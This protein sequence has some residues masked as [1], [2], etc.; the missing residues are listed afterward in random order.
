M[1]RGTIW[2]VRGKG[3]VVEGG[4]TE[5]ILGNVANGWGCEQPIYILEAGVPSSKD[6][7]I[8]FARMSQILKLLLTSRQESFQGT[9][10]R[11]NIAK[12]TMDPGV[13]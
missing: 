3:W 10:S 11:E 2:T 6:K 13:A 1:K 5:L 4:L 8:I 7:C 9:F 12:G